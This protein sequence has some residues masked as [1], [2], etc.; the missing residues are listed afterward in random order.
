MG[1]PSVGQRSLCNNDSLNSGS[2][3]L[4]TRKLRLGVEMRK[5][6]AFVAARSMVS[7]NDW[8]LDRVNR[9]SKDAIYFAREIIAKEGLLRRRQAGT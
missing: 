6:D 8:H 1:V 2:E 4:F 7:Q 5:G 3:W 9:N